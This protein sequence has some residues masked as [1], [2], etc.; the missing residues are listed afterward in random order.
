MTLW[1]ISVTFM[2]LC[3][4]LCLRGIH[5]IF[6]VIVKSMPF[7]RECGVFLLETKTVGSELSAYHCIQH[8]LCLLEYRGN[9]SVQLL[10]LK[11]EEF[12]K[13]RCIYGLSSR[14]ELDN[15]TIRWLVQFLRIGFEIYFLSGCRRIFPYSYTLEEPLIRLFYAGGIYESV[16]KV[17]RLGIK[18]LLLI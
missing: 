9:P 15:V 5:L 16:I 14:G 2:D 7:N 1:L 4:A 12:L 18:G 3:L 10:V 8:Q 11:V 13:E 17:G 6:G